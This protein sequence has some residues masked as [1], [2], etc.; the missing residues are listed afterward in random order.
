VRIVLV[1]DELLVAMLIE[2]I[3]SEAG[4]EVVATS[5]TGERA[6]ALAAECRPDLVLMDYRLGGPMTGVEA[7]DLIWTAYGIPSLFISGNA[8][9]LQ[10][11]PPAALGA[12]GKPVDPHRLAFAL[13]AIALSLGRPT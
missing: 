5:S 4:H 11:N 13:D 3:V 9:I 1:E 10:A 12:M 6:V 2:D 7:A 8:S